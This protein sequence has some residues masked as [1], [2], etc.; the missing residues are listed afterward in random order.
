MAAL[1]FESLAGCGGVTPITPAAVSPDGAALRRWTSIRTLI[2]KWNG[3]TWSVAK[4]PNP[5]TT[6]D[7]LRAIA[8]NSAGLWAVGRQD[9]NVSGHDATSLVEFHCSLKKPAILPSESRTNINGTVP[10]AKV[11]T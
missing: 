10:L 9:S 7:Q 4:S 1:A 3:S 11:A 5:A 2:E 8:S 6:Y